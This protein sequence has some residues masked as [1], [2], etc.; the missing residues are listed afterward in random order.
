VE[1]PG[2]GDER[3]RGGA[4]G[5]A[6]LLD[7]LQSVNRTSARSRSTWRAVRARASPPAWPRTRTCCGELQAGG[8]GAPWASTTPRSRMPTRA[9]VLLDHRVRRGAGASSPGMTWWFRRSA[10]DEHHRLARRR[11]Q[12]VGVALVMSSAG[13]SPPPASSQRC[14]PRPHRRGPAV[15]VDLALEPARGAGQPGLGLH[16]GRRVGTRWAR[17][18][19]HRPPYELLTPPTARWSLPWAPTSSSGAC[20]PCWAPRAGPAQQLRQQRRACGQPRAAG[21]RAGAAAG[22]AR[23]G[24][25]GAGA[26]AR[27]VPSGQVNDIAARFALAESLGLQRSSRSREQR[28]PAQPERQPDQAVRDP[29]TYRCAPRRCPGEKDVTA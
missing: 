2:T 24:R 20:V 23:R 27:G 17:R 26:R 25:M 10:A 28:A 5:R 15:E 9:G 14:A 12:K 29:V 18:T 3:A 8:D 11:A 4:V 16:A 19:Q 13:C 1:R 7:L 21:A 6:R 22:A